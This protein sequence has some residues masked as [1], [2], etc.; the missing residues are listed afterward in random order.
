MVNTF[1]RSRRGFTLVEIMV[2]IAIL[3]F[4]GV[5][6][7]SLLMQSMQSYSAGAGEDYAT[8]Q[9]TIALQKL[10]TDIRDGSLA[11]T[12]DANTT[13]VV[14]FPAK[15]RDTAT[16]QDYYD[17]TATDPVKNYYY[18]S[19]GNLVRRIG[20]TITVLGRG[21]TAATFEVHGAKVMANLTSTERM[22]KAEQERQHEAKGLVAMRNFQD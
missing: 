10:T 16:G 19:E 5:G 12:Q 3:S 15:L 7:V 6:L 13:L 9:A 1:V 14:S 11:T 21:V 8:S 18:V 4:V 17:P 22:G 2:S 20:T